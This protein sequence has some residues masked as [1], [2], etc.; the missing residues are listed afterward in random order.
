MALLCVGLLIGFVL[1]RL[2][3]TDGRLQFGSRLPKKNVFWTRHEEE[4]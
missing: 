2:R 4:K 1:G 3:I